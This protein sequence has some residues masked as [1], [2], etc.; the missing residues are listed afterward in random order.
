MPPTISVFFMTRLL[1]ISSSLNRIEDERKE[2][3][4]KKR[5]NVP[6]NDAADEGANRHDVLTEARFH[7]ERIEEKIW[8]DVRKQKNSEKTNNVDRAYPKRRNLEK[9]RRVDHGNDFISVF[10]SVLALR[11]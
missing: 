10:V 9:M 2:P 7:V 3:D 6:D 1:Q 11:P 5:C 8:T 4:A